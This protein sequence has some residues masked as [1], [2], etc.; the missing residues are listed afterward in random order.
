MITIIWYNNSNSFTS[1][2]TGDDAT[3]AYGAA[4]LCMF[5]D[6]NGVYHAKTNAW[7]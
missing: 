1:K 6:G 7:Q 5:E 2:G 3:D 4:A